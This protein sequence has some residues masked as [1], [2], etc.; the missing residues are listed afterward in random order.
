[1]NKLL[2]I[3]AIQLIPISLFSQ[4]IMDGNISSI[5]ISG[6][7]KVHVTSSQSSIAGKG[8]YKQQEMYMRGNELVISGTIPDPVYVQA[9]SLNKIDISGNG[10]VIMDS[11]AFIENLVIDVSGNGKT[12][13]NLNVRNL[14]VAVSGNYTGEWKGNVDRM[15]LNVSGRGVV[16]A[17]GMKVKSTHV[18]VSGMLKAFLDV[19]DS[20]VTNISGKATVLYKSRP[21]FI[22]GDN[23][24]TARLGDMNTAMSDTTRI[25]LGKKEILIIGDNEND[26]WKLNKDEP[27][28]SKFHWAGFE[29]G[30]NN[31]VNRNNKIDVPQGYSYLEL[32]TGKSVFVNI[33]LLEWNANIY[34]EYI[35]IG[36]GLGFQF[37]NYRFSNRAQ[38]LRPDV[39]SVSTYPATQSY[40]KYKL[41]VD[42][43]SLPVLLEFNTSKHKKRSFHFGGGI[44]ANYKI[45]ARV[46]LKSSSGKEKIHDDYNLRPFK[47]E[48]RVN[49]GY[50]WLNLFATYGMESMFREKH[51]PDLNPVSFGITLVDW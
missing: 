5:N 49:I 17:Y 21:S 44:V 50:G 22:S 30:L 37:N 7:A 18:N 8:A 47:L 48:A 20:L 34:K 40:S 39:E 14:A 35:M 28:K 24:G 45:G 25:T 32:N 15:Q 3:L 16:R 29:M 31:Y 36:T 41:A 51:G 38:I 2:S 1:M 42:Y 33:N 46:K 43:I 10:E 6:S 26:R 23:S 9:P 13:L 11:S 12:D 19:S 27:S 4:N